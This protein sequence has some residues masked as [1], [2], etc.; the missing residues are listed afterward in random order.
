MTGGL[1][2]GEYPQ[3][4]LAGKAP[5]RCLIAIW[6]ALILPFLPC[7]RGNCQEFSMCKSLRRRCHV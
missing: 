5:C 6:S 1:S 3:Q 7:W 2:G 4:P